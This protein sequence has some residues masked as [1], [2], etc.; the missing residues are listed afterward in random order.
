MAQHEGRAGSGPGPLLNAQLTQRPFPCCLART[1]L[2]QHGSYQADRPQVHRWQGSSQAARHQG[3]RSRDLE[4]SQGRAW[5]DCH[6]A[7]ATRSALSESPALKGARHT[8][9]CPSTKSSSRHIRNTAPSCL[10]AARAAHEKSN[11]L[12][13]TGSR[14]EHHSHFSC[15]PIL[16]TTLSR[17]CRYEG[18]LRPASCR[19]VS[20]FF[21]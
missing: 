10:S 15:M 4:R 8:A 19:N 3:T 13:L 17:K 5:H 9:L 21:P 2:L 18:L 6:S 11:C 1:A 14:T 12:D 16:L 7:T 20:D